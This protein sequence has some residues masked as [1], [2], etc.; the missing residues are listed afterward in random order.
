MHRRILLFFI[1]LMPLYLLGQENEIDRLS[2]SD[3][4]VAGELSELMSVA[5]TGEAGSD[6]DLIKWATRVISEKGPRHYSEEVERIKAVKNQIKAGLT[7]EDITTEPDQGVIIPQIEQSFDA[8]WMLNG[9]PPDDALAV[10][11][12][13][14][15]V[16]CNN[17]GIEYYNSN[18]QFIGAQFWSDFFTDPQLTSS[19]FDPR[20][21]YDSGADRFVMVVLHGSDFSTSRVLVCFSNSNDPVDGWVVYQLSGDPDSK[22]YWFDY[23]NL[24]IGTNEVYITGNM[25]NRNGDFQ[26]AYIYQIDKN[27]GYRRENLSFQ[28]WR[29]LTRTPFSAFTLVPASYGQAG[30]YG[31]GIYLVSNNPAGGNQIRFWDLTNDI[32]KNP[33]LRTATINVQP[34]EPAADALQRGSMDRLQSGGCRIQE[35]FYLDKELHFVFAK[36][37][38]DTWSGISYHRLNVDNLSIRESSFGLSGSFDYAYPSL[39]SF[40]RNVAD[41][42]AMISFLRSS[43]NIFPEVRVV[44]V[45][46]N[47]EWSQSI[48]VRE[49]DNF[50]DIVQGDERWGDYTSMARQH[51][52]TNPTVW[53]SGSYGGDILQ[54]NRRNTYITHIARIGEEMTSTSD[55]GESILDPVVFPNPSYDEFNLSFTLE[56]PEM[57][58]IGI[59]DHLGRSIRQL[60]EDRLNPGNHQ[61]KFNKGVLTQGRY[62]VVI[63]NQEKILVNET[64]VIRH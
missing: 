48:L 38:G 35:A 44:S 45:D 24:A 10:S 31:P 50:V 37:I 34:Y 21:E 15:I 26:E 33:Q 63:K 60:F 4:E 62:H 3:F 57:I 19:I 29:N 39:V 14:K 49:G 17:D 11:N 42:S 18:G 1:F 27:S 30:N 13:G 25:F 64:L 46:D 16:T 32:G 20:V 52:A 55:E 53:M 2:D 59:Y 36:D 41:E 40:S 7:T 5:P 51:N 8:N 61:L 6:I 43:K 47:M 56:R 54:R 58:E 28:V 12:D 9:T 23:P 22:G